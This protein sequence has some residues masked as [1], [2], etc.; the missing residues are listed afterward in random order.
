MVRMKVD[1]VGPAFPGGLEDV[2]TPRILASEAVSMRAQKMPR[3][4]SA[5]V[6]ESPLIA[7][8][9]WK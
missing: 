5:G 1:P 6:L 3:P 8:H 7:F 9:D 2:A 4:V